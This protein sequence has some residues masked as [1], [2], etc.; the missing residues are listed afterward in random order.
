M[1]DEVYVHRAI[2]PLKPGTKPGT[3]K[4][5]PAGAEDLAALLVQ[6]VREYER[7]CRC[8]KCHGHISTGR[9]RSG[10]LACIE[11]E[12][13]LAN[14]RK[15]FLDDLLSGDPAKTGSQP[16]A[17]SSEV[18]DFS[19]VPESRSVTFPDMKKPRKIKTAKAK[20]KTKAKP[21]SKIGKATPR[22]EKKA[23]TPKPPR[24]KKGPVSINT[25]NGTQY[26][27]Q[28]FVRFDTPE[29]KE[30]VRKAANATGVS[31]SAYIAHFAVAAAEAGKEYKPPKEE[32]KE[33]PV[34]ATG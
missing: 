4:P 16:V 31:L 7:N 1:T 27:R 15:L 17:S 32:K 20:A 30:M 6:R 24:A 18:N 2:I 26:D 3:K 23:A 19:C 14:L 28:V 13:C 22:A 5:M 10:P 33:E 29:I 21:K 12:F 9:A 11:C 34:E 25:G 8:P